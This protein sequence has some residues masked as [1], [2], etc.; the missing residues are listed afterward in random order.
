MSWALVA[1]GGGTRRSN[2]VEA[3]AGPTPDGL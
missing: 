1:V 3:P 2:S